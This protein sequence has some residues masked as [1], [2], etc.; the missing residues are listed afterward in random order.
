MTDLEKLREELDQ[1]IKTYENIIKDS[2]D[3]QTLFLSII[4]DFYLR[5]QKVSQFV[6]SMPNEMIYRKMNLTKLI[7]TTL[8]NVDYLMNELKKIDFDCKMQVMR[9]K[10]QHKILGESNE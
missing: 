4:K 2:G 8:L 1:K 3:T 6:N 9:L 7:K 5:L 10:H